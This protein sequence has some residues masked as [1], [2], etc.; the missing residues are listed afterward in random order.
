MQELCKSKLTVEEYKE[1]MENVSAADKRTESRTAWRIEGT[2]REFPRFPP[3]NIWFDYPVHKADYS[4]V[5]KD[6]EAESDTPGWQK[7]IHKRKEKNAEKQD[8]NKAKFENAVALSNFGNPPTVKQIMES[9]THR[10]L[11]S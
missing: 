6:L 2:L 5:L 3:I 11:R 4:D 7:A 9:K 8:K 10:R 1:A